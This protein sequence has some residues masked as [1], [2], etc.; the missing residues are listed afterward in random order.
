MNTTIYNYFKDTF[1]TIED[2]INTELKENYKNSS[3]RLLRMDP[4]YLKNINAPIIIIKII[5]I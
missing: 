3:A 4:K 5:I 1:G 2:P